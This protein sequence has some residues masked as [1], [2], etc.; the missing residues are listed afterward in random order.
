MSEDKF[1]ESNA[2]IEDGEIVSKNDKA[3]SMKKDKQN[4]AFIQISLSILSGIVG[5]IA[6]NIF[7]GIYY[8]FNVFVILI[9]GLILWIIIVYSSN[10]KLIILFVLTKNN[11]KGV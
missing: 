10:W 1:N 2:S 3:K 11:L 8:L 5:G 9:I 7:D 4:E 6:V